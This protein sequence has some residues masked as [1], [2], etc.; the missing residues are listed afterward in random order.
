LTRGGY[1]LFHGWSGEC[2]RTL[3][4]ARELGIPTLLEIP[5]WHRHKGKAK[6]TRQTQSERER[7]EA[8]GWTGL[9]NRLLISRQQVLEEYGLADRILVL[10]AKAEETFLAAGI[11]PEKLF[12]HQR[13]VDVERFRPAAKT[14]EKFIALF[15]GALIK[16]K[17]VH[18]LL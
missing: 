6:P 8:R 13:G 9:K 10:S 3:R 5:T 15:V 16:R 4:V 2:V 14:P 17:G 12:R 1:D 7:S 18:H 11:A